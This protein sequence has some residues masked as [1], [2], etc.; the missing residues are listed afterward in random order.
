MSIGSKRTA[1]A[2]GAGSG[3]G[4]IGGAAATADG[5]EPRKRKRVDHSASQ[6]Q[7]EAIIVSVNNT[8]S[9]KLARAG[10]GPT[11]GN[12]SAAPLVCFPFSF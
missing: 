12:N 3:G 9:A 7:R 2:V 8:T 1:G 11:E 10:D 4:G 5:T 6:V